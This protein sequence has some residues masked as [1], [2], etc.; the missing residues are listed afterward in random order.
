MA[1]SGNRGRHA[2]LKVASVHSVSVLSPN[3]LHRNPP[4]PNPCALLVVRISGSTFPKATL[5]QSYWL[6]W[7]RSVGLGGFLSQ[8][9]CNR[10]GKSK[11]EA[12]TPEHELVQKE[13]ECNKASANERLHSRNRRRPSRSCGSN[14]K[15]NRVSLENLCCHMPRKLQSNPWMDYVPCV[16]LAVHGVG[17]DGDKNAPRPAPIEQDTDMFKQKI[18]LLNESAKRARTESTT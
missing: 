16:L 9:S 3:L 8:P 1:G 6:Q 12:P 15:P 10:H 2:S 7:T 18:R 14:S 4:V 13:S 17:A 11:A 5:S